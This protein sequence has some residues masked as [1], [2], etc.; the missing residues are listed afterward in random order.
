[1]RSKSSAYNFTQSDDQQNFPLTISIT[2]IASPPQPTCCQ[3]Q[4][5]WTRSCH[6]MKC[7]HVTGCH[8]KGAV[9][10]SLGPFH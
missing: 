7:G 2:D 6:N 4:G 5:L 1:M 8:S 9:E 10:V 3:Y